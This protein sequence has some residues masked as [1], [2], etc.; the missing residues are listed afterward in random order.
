MEHVGTLVGTRTWGGLVGI[1]RYPILMDGG[2]V[3]APEG[4]IY[5]PNGNWDVENHGVTPNVQVRLNPALWRQGKD[6]QLETAVAIALRELK[7]HPW[8][9]V[10]RPPYP[11]YQKGTPFARTDTS[12]A[13]SPATGKASTQK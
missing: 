3:T 1:G 5:F 2:M 12:A 13:K 8:H 6:P 4:A 7:A 9:I 10:P 11:D